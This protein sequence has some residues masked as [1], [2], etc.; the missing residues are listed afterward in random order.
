M[1][2]EQTQVYREIPKMKPVKIVGLISD[3]HVPVRARCI[4]E[5]VFKIFEKADFIV[6]AGDLVELAVVDEL[7][8]LAPVL[9][10]HGNM[11]GPE[12]SG[13]LPKLNSLKVSDWK[14]GVM[15]D[16]NTM[17]GMGK[18]REIAKQNGFNVFVYGHT[19]NSSIKWEGKTLYINPGSPTNP[20]SFIVKP[21][22]AILKVTRETI[23]PEIIHI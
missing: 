20:S 8:Q 13:A 4:P 1:T 6:H 16:P 19:H 11:D 18:M 12:V 22:V 5:K 9:A 15:H 23:T 3:T 2:S 21:S 14:I 17:F 7:E 10:V